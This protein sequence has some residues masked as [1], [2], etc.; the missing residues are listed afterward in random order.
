MLIAA[1]ASV[2]PRTLEKALQLV[3]VE[4]PAAYFRLLVE[5]AGLRIAIDVEGE[6]FSVSGSADALTVGAPARPCALE[7]HATRQCVLNLLDG[8]CTLLQAVRSRGLALWGPSEILPRV[9]RAGTAFS[10]GAIR[11]RPMRGL[12]EEL[13]TAYGDPQS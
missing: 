2:T 4:A 6:E 12:L 11:V 1:P 9:A 10:E 13:R 8:H 3:R 7:L 5:C